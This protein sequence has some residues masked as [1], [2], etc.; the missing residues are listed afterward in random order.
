MRPLLTTFLLS[1]SITPAYFQHS[2]DSCMDE[3]D[4]SENISFL[5]DGIEDQDSEAKESL[6]H[7]TEKMQEAVET[8]SHNIPT[9]TSTKEEENLVMMIHYLLDEVKS[10]KVQVEHQSSSNAGV[11]YESKSGKLHSEIS[12]DED[13]EEDNV[14]VSSKLGDF[15]PIDQG[16]W[17]SSKVAEQAR[18]NFTQT[19]KDLDISMN[20]DNWSKWD[21]YF[22]MLVESLGLPTFI[23]S[24]E[25]VQPA[26]TTHA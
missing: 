8:E 5:R 20:E 23:F 24:L 12:T 3:S 2:I 25:K 22:K 7:S 10:L 16:R 11:T 26:P 21:S 9:V 15:I 4:R 13:L 18:L 1:E 6:D 14:S 17:K 19:L